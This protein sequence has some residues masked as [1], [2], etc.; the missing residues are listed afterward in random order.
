MLS[1]NTPRRTALLE[2][3]ELIHEERVGRM[4]RPEPVQRGL[5]RERL[6]GDL[7]QLRGSGAA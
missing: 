7:A 4:A 3:F 2:R 5:E 1:V 6:R